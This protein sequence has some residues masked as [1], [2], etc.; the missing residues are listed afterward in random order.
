MNIRLRQCLYGGM[1][2]GSLLAAVGTAQYVEDSIDCGGRSVHSLCYN[3]R[4]GVVYGATYDGPFFAISAES[5]K[6]VS[7]TP[8]KHPHWV[9][10]D[11]L[12]NKAYCLTLAGTIMVVDGATHGRIGQIAE[13]WGSCGVWNPDND[14]LYVSSYFDNEVVVIDCRGDTVLCRIRVGRDPISVTL[15]RRRQKLYV[16]NTD[17][18]SVSIIDLVTNRVIRTIRL[19]DD[20]PYAGCY[21]ADADRYFCCSGHE[22]FVIDGVGD[23]VTGRVRVSERTCALAEIPTHGLVMVAAG[24]SVMTFTAR[25]DSVVSRLRAGHNPRALL[26]SAQTDRVYAANYPEDLAVITGDGSRVVR[27]VPVGDAPLSLALAPAYQRLYVGHM[28][29]RFVYVIRDTASGIGEPRSARTPLPQAVNASPSPFTTKVVFRSSAGV[30]CGRVTVVCSSD[31]RVVRR[32]ASVCGRG[33][34]PVWSWDGRNE[35]GEEAPRGVYLVSMAGDENRT[36]VIKL[37]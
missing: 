25:G 36:A 14:R 23:T 7:S 37:K 10:Y 16:L 8:V 3:S 31:G 18:E 22:V 26:W 24:E 9:V 28:N 30:R 15:N 29:G 19:S 11:S 32:L 17:S 35:Q 6:V 2:L 5:N 34:E 27:T 1:M 4:A 13:V 21:S 33:G 20:M 12:D